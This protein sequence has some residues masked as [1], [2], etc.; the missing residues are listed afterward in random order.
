MTQTEHQPIPVRIAYVGG[1]SLNWAPVLMADLAADPR[2]VAEVRLHDPDHE[3]AERNARL[4]ARFAEVATGR[5]A[6]WRGVRD[7]GEALEGAD[8][9]VVSIL[10]GT[11]GDMAADIGIPA[12]YGIPQ[13]VGDTVG[14][15]GFVRALRAVPMMLEIGRAIRVHAPDAFVC[16]LTNPMSVLTDA[17]FRAHPGIR[18]WGECHEVT[19]LR[20][21]V[22]W[23]ANR[24]E[25]GAA[26]GFRDVEVD[27]LGIN[28]F[29]FVTGIRL[30]GRDMLRDWT[31]FAEAHRERGWHEAVPDSD[32]EH[33]RYFSS[34]SRVKFDLFRRFGLPAAAG[35]RHLA[36]FLPA[37]DYLDDAEGWGFALTP[38]DYR[39]RDRAARLAR[40]EAMIEGRV[41]PVAKRSDEALIDQFAALMGGAEHVSNVNLPNRGQVP[42]LPRGAVVETNA[43]FGRDGIA[44]IHAGAI[45]D[46]LA[47]IVA[48]H[49]ARQTG[50][51]DA[52]LA[53]DHGA[54]FPLFASDPLV[55]PLS[56]AEARAMFAEMLAATARWLP[57]ALVA[58]AA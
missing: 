19:K 34:R 57:D 45:P 47:A 31:A 53:G 7:L 1:G 44:P 21:Q 8:L 41:P 18:A 11:L 49:A 38:V 33:A 39:L 24:Q 15:G 55:R 25:P 29:T 16:N 9:V 10:P 22:A 2:L 13:A 23:I 40:A 6:T 26:Y 43:R 20:R 36:E 3:A 28:H 48:D 50:L 54:L 14:P 12:R 46:P 35:D 52:V 5:P 4:G 42:N 32:D 27:V 37:S 56:E 17:L 51:V 30:A 58:E